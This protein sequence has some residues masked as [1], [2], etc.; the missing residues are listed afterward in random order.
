MAT[1]E[2]IRFDEFELDLSRYELRRQG[3][4]VKL[5]KLPLRLLILLVEAEG[6]LVTRQEIADRLWGQD[7]F[8]DTEHGINTAIRKIRDALGD[9][10]EQPRI[11]LTVPGMGYRLVAQAATQP[12]PSPDQPVD[13]PAVV[14]ESAAYPRWQPWTAMAAII[15]LAGVGFWLYRRSATPT[16]AANKKVMLAVLP[17]ENLSGNADQEYFSDGLTEELLTDLGSVQ[18]EQLGVIARTSVMRYKRS[19]TPID[20]I[21]RQLGVDYVLEGSVRRD[22]S[23]VRVSAQ[24]IRARDQV[25]IWAHN[26]EYELANILA[27][28]AEVSQAIASEIQLKL[29]PERQARLKSRPSV[30]PTAYEAYLRGRNLWFHEFDPDVCPETRRYFET[31]IAVDPAYAPAYAGLADYYMMCGG[32]YEMLD[33]QELARAGESAARRAVALDPSLALTHNSLAGI[34][35]AAKWDCAG[36]E[37][38]SKQAVSRDPNFAEAHNL[39]SYILA[40][41]G[42][43]DEA[44]KEAQKS[45]ALDPVA[46]GSGLAKV[47]YDVRRFELAAAEAE[48]A[49]ALDQDSPALHWLLFRVFAA[50]GKSQL[51]VQ[52]LRKAVLLDGDF[53]GEAEIAA[54]YHGGDFQ[55]VLRVLAEQTKGAS[56]QTTMQIA[57]AYA[58]ARDRRN[59]LEWLNR[60]YQR[61]SAGLIWIKTYPAFDFLAGDPD[62][63]ALLHRI[64]LPEG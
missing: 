26:Y 22:G 8:H 63:K 10:P 46:R 31:A 32:L 38:E 29:T 6:R 47:Y 54:A 61:H 33:Q 62:Y 12:G 19:N 2:T 53:Q 1:R 27:L 59:T 55:R 49:L 40:S 44:V 21:A 42:Q 39:Y 64:G 43:P 35:F 15:L 45:H 16:Q 3:R 48:R 57:E 13:M 5:Q 24:L 7:V 41:C 25:H 34:L 60:A 20:A 51:S 52:H 4:P 17:F 37:A 50:Q 9:D 23:R 11:V 36:A 56:G 30:N 18:P 58:L 28:Q 14:P